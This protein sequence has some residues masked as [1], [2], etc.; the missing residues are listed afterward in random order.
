MFICWVTSLL[1][2]PSFHRWNNKKLKVVIYLKSCKCNEDFMVPT[3]CP[4]RTIWPTPCEIGFS[5]LQHC[6]SAGFK[7]FEYQCFHRGNTTFNACKCPRCKSP[8]LAALLKCFGTFIRIICYWTA[9]SKLSYSSLLIVHVP[10][11]PPKDFF[12]LKVVI[13][14][15]LKL[16]F[17]L[18]WAPPFG[19]DLPT[20]T[21][22]KSTNGHLRWMDC[23]RWFIW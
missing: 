21:G 17:C 18:L 22:R 19:C 6:S 1:C 2:C 5:P 15:H 12:F 13:R 11:A 23:F 8:H 10:N 9:W 3:T 4:K 16:L 7:N 20:A 14:C